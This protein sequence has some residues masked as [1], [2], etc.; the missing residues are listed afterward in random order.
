MS[1]RSECE[2][3]TGRTSDKLWTSK[4]LVN[5]LR[6]SLK[7]YK[8]AIKSEVRQ[9]DVQNM[10]FMRIREPFKAVEALKSKRCGSCLVS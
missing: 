10:Q 7:Q 9:Q 5:L 2:D 8:D 6:K 3:S 4:H 1:R